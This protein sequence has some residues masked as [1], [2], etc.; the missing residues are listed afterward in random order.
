MLHIKH[1][2]QYLLYSKHSINVRYINNVVDWKNKEPGLS[3]LV[4]FPPLTDSLCNLDQ[5][6]FPL[7]LTLSV[8]VKR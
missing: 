2:K 7:G 4:L 6:F 5:V 1:L 8:K 3:F